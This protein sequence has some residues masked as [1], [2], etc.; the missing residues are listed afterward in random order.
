[1]GCVRLGSQR[2]TRLGA[3]SCTIP[4][5][6]ALPFTSQGIRFHGLSIP[7]CQEVLPAA[8]GGKEILPESMLWFL[9]TGQVPTEEQTRQLSRELAERGELPKYAEQLIDS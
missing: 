8:P 7:E 6:N 9:M 4:V 2:G 1:L 5:A 3:R